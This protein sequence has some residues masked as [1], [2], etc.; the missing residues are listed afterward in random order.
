MDGQKNT[1]L[2]LSEPAFRDFYGKIEANGMSIILL[3]N[4][5]TE[6]TDD[7]KNEFKEIATEFGIEI[8][9]K[10]EEAIEDLRKRKLGGK[11]LR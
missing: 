5:M 8:G 4:K 10:I 2:S 9:E 3:Y 11:T 6:I 1:I 7:V